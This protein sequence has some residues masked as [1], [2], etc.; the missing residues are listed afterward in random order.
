M[1]SVATTLACQHHSI[2]LQRK[3]EHDA[4]IHVLYL[5]HSCEHR[6]HLQLT[7]S[8]SRRRGCGVGVYSML[9]CFCRCSTSSLAQSEHTSKSHAAG[10]TSSGSV[11]GSAGRCSCRD[12]TAERGRVPDGGRSEEDLGAA[13]LCGRTASSLARIFEACISRL[14]KAQR[15]GVIVLL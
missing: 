11:A 7:G 14:S 5:Q 4:L 10:C 1:H 13:A 3:Q 6:R 8:E 12:T 15:N 9:N 2:H